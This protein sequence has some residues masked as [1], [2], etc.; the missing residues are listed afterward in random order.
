MKDVY[1][2]LTSEDLK[3][4]ERE[5]LTGGRMERNIRAHCHTVH[6]PYLRPVSWPRKVEL[7]LGHLALDTLT[8]DVRHSTCP[9]EHCSKEN[10]AI[11]AFADGFK[12][13]TPA[14]LGFCGFGKSGKGDEVPKIMRRWRK[15]RGE[16]S[17]PLNKGVKENEDIVRAV[18]SEIEESGISTC[19][20]MWRTTW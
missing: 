3:Y 5:N 10:S 13:G 19:N 2:L 20:V 7:V 11:A 1:L 17:I 4:E 9:N 15:R 16:V 14:N 12:H 6:M 8:V 18:E